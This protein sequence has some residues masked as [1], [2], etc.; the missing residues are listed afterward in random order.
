MSK[1]LKIK[2]NVDLVGLSQPL[3]LVN[4]GT[5][6]ATDI[7]EISL[8]NNSLIVPHLTETTDVVVD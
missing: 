2:D 7:S 1:S 5:L 3:P 6:L 4:L 8:N